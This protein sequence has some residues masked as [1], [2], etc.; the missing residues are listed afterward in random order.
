MALEWRNLAG[1]SVPPNWKPGAGLG[2]TETVLRF[3]EIFKF[4]SRLSLTAAGD[5][6]MH[7]EIHV[8]NLHGRVL[9]T[10]DPRRVS[11]PWS[12]K[13]TIHEFPVVKDLPKVHLIA[14][15]GEL[16]LQSSKDLF[17]RFGW[18]PSTELLQGIQSG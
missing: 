6:Q 14:K 10:D 16:A 13:T 11:M 8:C 4:A 3:S 2:I 12:Y 18:N 9:M 17:S 15:H 7:I 5:E 1:G